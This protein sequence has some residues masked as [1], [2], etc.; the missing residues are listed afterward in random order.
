MAESLKDVS[1]G[2]PESYWPFPRPVVKL[3]PEDRAHF[4]ALTPGQRI[5][6]LVMMLRL[7]EAQ[8]RHWV[9]N[10]QAHS[11]ATQTT[12]EQRNPRQD[13]DGTRCRT[14]SGF[15]HL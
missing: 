12:E 7:L 2:T 8:F 14:C 9:T 10:K 11:G 1:W 6:W 15:L 4:Q 3:E 5:E 13:P